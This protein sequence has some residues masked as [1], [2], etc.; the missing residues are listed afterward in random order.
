MT[1]VKDLKGLPFLA[2]GGFDCRPTLATMSGCV[3]TVASIFDSDPRTETISDVSFAMGLCTHEM[4]PTASVSS[5]Q[6]TCPLVTAGR[7]HM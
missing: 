3:A 1:S 2:G 5:C 7:L 4:L 6:D